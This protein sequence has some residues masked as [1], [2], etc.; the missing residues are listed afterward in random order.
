MVAGYSVSDHLRPLVEWRID[1]R[2]H[3]SRQEGTSP[4]AL[5]LVERR[6]F[7]RGCLICWLEKHCDEVTPIPA[8]D[9]EAALRPDVLSRSVAAIIGMEP[10][11]Q[12]DWLY[13]QIALLRARDGGLPIMLIVDSD[14]IAMA[15]ELTAQLDLQGYI[16]AFSSLEVAAAAVRLILAG[17]TYFPRPQGE[18]PRQNDSPSHDHLTNRLARIAELT[19]RE[20]AVLGLLGSG[21]PNK[22]IA[23]RLGLSL[24]TVKA[25]VHHIIRKL[26]VGNRT[27][28]ALLIQQPYSIKSSKASAAPILLAPAPRSAMGAPAGNSGAPVDDRADD[29]S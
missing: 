2:S 15:A 1:P 29:F 6:E 18:T 26:Q 20:R 4:H 11:E 19:A 5:I 14:Q 24:S 8:A 21:T 7:I 12:H 13:S 3:L 16:P 22:I 10:S 23:H 9:V 27:E 25:H 17:G 28:V